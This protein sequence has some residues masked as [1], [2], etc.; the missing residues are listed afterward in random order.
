MQLEKFLTR[1]RHRIAVR[2]TIGQL[3]FVRLSSIIAIPTLIAYLFLPAPTRILLSC[4]H[5]NISQR[6]TPP[7][8]PTYENIKVEVLLDNQV[9]TEYPDRETRD[10]D[11]P[12]CYIEAQSDEEYTLRVTFCKGFETEGADCMCVTPTFDGDPT[13]TNGLCWRRD[14]PRLASRAGRL[15]QD[16]VLD[17]DTM[18]AIDKQSGQWKRFSFYFRSLRTGMY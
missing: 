9:L 18:T 2:P 3:H 10:A 17:I 15:S 5:L 14:M 1:P 7:I 16:V 4:I 13:Q 11:H 8:M 12:T 6:T